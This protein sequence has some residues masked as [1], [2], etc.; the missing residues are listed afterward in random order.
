M[1][2]NLSDRLQGVFKKLRGH[3]KLTDDNI[4]DALREV[5]IALLEADVNF[6][7]VKRFVNR[8]SERAVGADVLRSLTPGQQV[9]K[10]VHQ[11]LI[12]LMGAR[13]EPLTRSKTPPTIYMLVGLQGSGKTTS[14]GKLAFMIRK[15]NRKTLLVA[16][17]I[18]RP[19]AIDQLKTLGRQ[20][21]VEVFAPGAEFD[22]VDICRDAVEKAGR[23]GFDTVILDTA[24]RLHIDTAL[25][26]ELKNIKRAV[27]PDEILLVADAM[28]GQD[29][30]NIATTFDSDLDISGV[31]L[32]KLDGDARGGAALSIK[33]VT[34]KPVKLVG[35]GEKLNPLEP[36]HPDRMASRILGMGDMLSLIEKA[37]REISEE[38]RMKMQK[39]LLDNSFNLED[40]K[41]QITQI[42]RLGSL[43]QVMS[44]IP[45]MGKVTKMQGMMPSEKD[46]RHVVAII[47][48]M[49]PEERRNPKIISTGRRRRIARGSGTELMDVNRLLK[50]FEQTRKM[51]KNIKKVGKQKKLGLGKGM[52]FQ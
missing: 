34:G 27:S 37:E 12:E 48:S 22:P 49:T 52:F 20:I 40:F 2:D 36:F 33:S 51:M 10:I 45:G 21:G 41:K 3:A 9:I 4:A 28:T 46:I 8:I 43:E 50:Q 31:I 26:D 5:R 15:D 38:D 35:M 23:E 44:M 19:A 7:V 24:G 1:F 25:M 17:D 13:A 29:A 47:D 42:Q 11:E 30:V 14:C 18:Y 39:K 16:A 32:T 6:R